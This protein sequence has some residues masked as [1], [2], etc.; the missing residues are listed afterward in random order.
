M[1][2]VLL[3]VEDHRLVSDRGH[4]R[5]DVGVILDD[6]VLRLV[7]L[8]LLVAPMVVRL[9]GNALVSFLGVSHSRSRTGLGLAP[10]NVS[11]FKVI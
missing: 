4:V 9:V 10:H 7:K 6:V 2:E 8:V 5:V 11:L 3:L 1:G